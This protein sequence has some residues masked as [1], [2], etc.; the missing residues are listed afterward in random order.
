MNR[1]WLRSLFVDDEQDLV[2]LIGEP[3]GSAAAWR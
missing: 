1:E 3:R 2:W